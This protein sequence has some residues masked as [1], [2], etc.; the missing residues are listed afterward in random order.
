LL[1]IPN[2]DTQVQP[3]PAGTEVKASLTLQADGKLSYQVPYLD[4]LFSISLTVTEFST[5]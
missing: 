5:L 4:K 2:F 1:L 3:I